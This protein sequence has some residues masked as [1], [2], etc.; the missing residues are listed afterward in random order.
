MAQNWVRL[1]PKKLGTQ[2]I[3]LVV[4]AVAFTFGLYAI[5]ALDLWHEK[6]PPRNVRPQQAVLDLVL[7][8][9]AR[10]RQ[11]D[12]RLS[13]II[14]AA[15]LLA[16]DLKLVQTTTDNTP[17][18]ENW[19]VVD[20]GMA[21]FMDR[22]HATGY[23]AKTSDTSPETFVIELQNGTILSSKIFPPVPPPRKSKLLS[24]G[25]F[26]PNRLL[27]LLFVL[28]IAL[29][30]AARK[31]S[32]Q[33]REFALAAENFSMEGSHTYLAE[34]GPEELQS[35][36]RSLNR[37][38]DRIIKHGKDRTRMLSAIGHD[39]RTPVTRMRLRAEFIKDTDMR[40]GLLKDI[41]RMDRMIE[42]ALS[43]FRGSRADADR[44]TLDLQSLVQTLCDNNADLGASVAC[45]PGPSLTLL[46][47]TDALE[48]AIEN[49]IHN[50]LR[51]A[52]N[53]R[54]G[55]S[56]TDPNHVSID[57]DDDGPG[58]DPDHRAS[59]LEPFNGGA[60]SGAAIKGEERFG[61]GLS[62]ASA[63]AQ[64][65]G[66]TLV[67]SDSDMGGLKASIILPL[68]IAAS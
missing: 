51:H 61:L 58:I 25:W 37:M 41:G 42:S 24:A 2:I 13:E 49:L 27:I 10:R 50:S 14:T 5:L 60:K 8:P 23:T 63:I 17:P 44:A 39:L 1:G 30:W 6:G 66:G 29:F 33:L 46:A 48:R 64:A 57:I 11:A 16:P 35:V 9:Q 59:L 43:F 38:R 15:N 34:S 45:A 31:I 22:L 54:V 40:E 47:D 12:P 36:A 52:K 65:H 67:L 53:V 62:I 26:S 55:L 56:L 68:E 28:P 20:G 32:I 7:R 21:K 4:L 18:R 19:T 3:V